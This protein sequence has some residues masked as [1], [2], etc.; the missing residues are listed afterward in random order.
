MSPKVPV[1]ETTGVRTRYANERP[2]NRSG[3]ALL[4]TELPFD[5]PLLE[6]PLHYVIGSEGSA[7]SGVL[8]L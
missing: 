3:R 6:E 4:V 5:G 8:P 7:L 2:I 1:T